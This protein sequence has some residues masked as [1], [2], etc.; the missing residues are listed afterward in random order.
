MI[1]KLGQQINPDLQDIPDLPK[2]WVPELV[3]QALEK[4]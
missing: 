2:Q 3:Q 1:V 4:F